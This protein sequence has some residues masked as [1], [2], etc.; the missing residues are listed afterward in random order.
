V[1]SADLLAATLLV[2]GILAAA[3][4]RAQTPAQSR[5]PGGSGTPRTE[6]GVSGLVGAPVSFGTSTAD[7]QRPDGSSLALFETGNRQGLELGGRLHLEAR[8]T[9]RV[10]VEI[11]GGVSRARL[12]TT[13]RDDLEGAAGV[14]LSESL[15][16]FDVD[17]GLVWTVAGNER[18]SWFVRGTGGW[19]R[20]LIGERVLGRHGVV[21]R[22]G[23]GMK[24]WG[25]R[26]PPGRV[27]Y[28]FRLEAHVATRWNGTALDAA[29][30]HL[31]PVVTA[32][33][34][35]GS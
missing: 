17:G 23:A 26:R 28:G 24:Y 33:L 34:M 25:P 29:R 1:R 6:F 13:I 22:V 14:V 10:A 30:I 12:E 21:A 8:V 32:G 7:L 18:L 2:V 3:P 31:A 4:A 15:V 9:R 16:R 27:R 20:E 35:I 19:M 11:A 5:G